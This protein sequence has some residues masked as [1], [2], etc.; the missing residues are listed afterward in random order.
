MRLPVV[1]LLLGTFGCAQREKTAGLHIDS[2]ADGV[3]AT[4]IVNGRAIGKLQESWWVSSSPLDSVA[5]EKGTVLVSPEAPLHRDL[6]SAFDG[7]VHPGARCRLEIVRV[8]GERIATVCD[9]G[10]SISVQANFGERKLWVRACQRTTSVGSSDS[11]RA[12]TKSAGRGWQ[13]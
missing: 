11:S 3:G 10:E 5:V 2:G 8:G 9:L 1:F 4:V 13:P 7:A 12:A 6:M